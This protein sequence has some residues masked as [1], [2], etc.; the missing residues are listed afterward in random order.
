MLNKIYESLVADALIQEKV[1]NRIKFYEYPETAILTDAHI[2]I[3]PLDVP[4]PSDFADNTWLKEDFLLQIEVWSKS[5]S[6]TQ[7]VAK[8]IR[9]I[10]WKLGFSQGGGVDEW[11]KDLNIFRDARRYRGKVYIN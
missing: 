10:M 8:R 11:D 9:E 1:E 7:I 6:D 4:I 2:I 3:D 5:L